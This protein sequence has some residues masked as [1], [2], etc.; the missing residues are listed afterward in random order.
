MLYPFPYL[1]Q[2]LLTTEFIFLKIINVYFTI[3]IYLLKQP[4]L[5]LKYVLLHRINA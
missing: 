1:N 4:I 2:L 5:S 3:F